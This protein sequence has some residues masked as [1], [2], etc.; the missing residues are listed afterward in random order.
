M[1]KGPTGLCSAS[2]PSLLTIAVQHVVV[3]IV[4]AISSYYYVRSLILVFCVDTVFHIVLYSLEQHSS[5]STQ[6]Q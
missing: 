4:L 1:I 3:S 6:Q 5:T 2:T